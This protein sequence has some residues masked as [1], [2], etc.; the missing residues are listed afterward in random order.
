[1]KLQ[2]DP[3]YVEAYSVH[4]LTLGS[5]T[6]VVI[7]I[8]LGRYLLFNTEFKRYCVI[9]VSQGETLNELEL[10]T[11]FKAL[12]GPLFIKQVME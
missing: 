9:E 11:A 8:G 12:Y 2:L 5:S 3:T 10:E 1:M 7:P 6:L 4:E